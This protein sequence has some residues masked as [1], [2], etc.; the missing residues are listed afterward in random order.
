MSQ[1]LTHVP[2]AA[3]AGGA[4]ESR[5]QRAKRSHEKTPVGGGE[6]LLVNKPALDFAAKE[7]QYNITMPQKST[8]QQPSMKEIEGLNRAQKQAAGTQNTVE[9]RLNRALEEAERLK[10]Q[11]KN[12][13]QLSK[14][15][16]KEEQQ[17]KENLLAEN[18][19]LKKQKE[20]LILGFKK[21]LKL[22]DIL[23]RQKMHFE[24]AKMLYFTEDEFMKALDWGKS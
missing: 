2:A 15:N 6:A 9:V 21:Q 8:L 22:I 7:E 1:T 4:M 18:K 14:D 20:E 5:S 12:T 24:A 13:K 3:A 11:L 23:K 10:T 16:T 17:Q 19:M